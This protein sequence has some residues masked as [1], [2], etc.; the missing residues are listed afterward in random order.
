MLK[1]AICDDS[2]SDIKMIHKNIST[3]FKNFNINFDI[4]TFSDAAFFL[5]ASEDK[6]F[7]VVFLDIDMP[8]INGLEVATELNKRN[9]ISEIIFVTNHDELVYKAFRFKAL[10]FV[11]KKHIETEMLEII[12]ILIEHINRRYKHILIQDGH[13]EKKAHI[14]DVIYMQSDDHYVNVVTSNGKIMI[15]KT[16]NDIESEYSVYGFIRIHLRYLVNYRYIYSIEKNVIILD[17]QEKLPLSRSRAKAVKDSF[18]FFSR[19]V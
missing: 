3:I 8:Q 19:R 2:K 7:D 18:Q 6:N 16:L 12:E 17:N 5:S 13:I 4:A 11:R 14:N 9:I 1:I 10:G 15:R